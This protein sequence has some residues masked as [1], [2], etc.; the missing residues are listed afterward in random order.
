M[1]FKNAIAAITI[2]LIPTLISAQE[3]TCDHSGKDALSN[4]VSKCL[5][6]YK[7]TSLS[8]RIKSTTIQTSS[9]NH[10]FAKN[11]LGE[12]KENYTKSLNVRNGIIIENIPLFKECESE[13]IFQQN[14]CFTE[15]L[16]NYLNSN[17]SSRMKKLDDEISTKFVITTEKEVTGL[18]ISLYHENESVKGQMLKTI[19]KLPRF[20]SGK[21]E[22]QVVKINYKNV[23]EDGRKI[24]DKTK[25][26]N[27]NNE[28]NTLHLKDRLIIE[29]NPLFKDCQGTSI[30]NQKKCFKTKLVDYL[31]NNSIR[32]SRMTKIHDENI[33]VNFVINKEKEFSLLNVKFNDENEVFLRKIIKDINKLPKFI[34]AN[35]EDMVVSINYETPVFN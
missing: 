28:S 10:R 27:Q 24:V 9:M 8:D 20:I 4:N 30:Y 5:K 32:Y 33:T 22:N 7:K 21:K 31:N 17:L 15:K 11:R 25:L 6:N 13:S 1:I 2:A 19:T 34:R 3:E 14:K 18:N 35:K 23:S 29:K 12:S 16:V 26:S